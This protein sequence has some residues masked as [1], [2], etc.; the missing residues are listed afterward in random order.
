MHTSP[1]W[2]ALAIGIAL[3]A[4]SAGAHA[5]ARYDAATRTFRLDGGEVTYAFGINDKQQLQSAYWGGRVAAGDAL[6]PQ[7]ARSDHSSFDLSA[8]ITPS[9]Y[10][11]FGGGV[12]SEVAL[13]SRTPQGV[14]DAVLTYQSHQ[15]GKDSVEV[16]LRDIGSPLEVTLHYTIDP[17]TGIVGRW[18]SIH[19]AGS[20]PLT[21]D[22]AASAAWSL[23]VQDD[24]RL[25]YMTGRWAGEWQMQRQ[26]VSEGATVLESR[27]NATG[28]QNTPW[29]AIDRD[30]RSNEDSGPV[31][32]GTLAWSGSW[33]ISVAR[34]QGGDVRVVGGYNPFDFAWPLAAG[35]TLDT[36]VMY[37]GYSN[38][39]MGG[40][41]RL[42]HRF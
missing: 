12:F 41:S 27:R 37:A 36:P 6:G 30:S 25:H 29:F 35:Q 3:V 31:W 14:R 1:R 10:P 9:E 38:Q 28:Q 19:N 34:L 40:A 42:Q 23:P 18:A 11:A 32:F 15:L 13:K 7:K 4:L 16:R 26:P 2:S 39:G 22:R 8:S 20:T 21:L 5:E 17:Q 24:Y 33:Q